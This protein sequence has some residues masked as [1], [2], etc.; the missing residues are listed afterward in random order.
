VRGH[1]RA[2]KAATSRRNPN[3]KRPP[4]PKAGY[5]TIARRPWPV[6]LVN[7]TV[8]KSDCILGAAGAISRRTPTE[9]PVQKQHPFSAREIS[10]SK[11]TL[12]HEN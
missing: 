11:E 9:K 3:Q 7:H 12:H 2:F 5:Q 8:K 6:I 10:T 4:F 1:V